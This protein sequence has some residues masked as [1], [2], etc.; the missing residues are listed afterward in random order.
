MTLAKQSVAGKTA[1]ITG[2]ASGIGAALVKQLCS[3]GA[4]VVA[5]DIQA[6]ALAEL[7]AAHGCVVHTADITTE[8]ANRDMVAT[9]VAAV[10]PLDLVFLNA[11]VLGRSREEQGQP[12]RVGELNPDHYRKVMAV[13]TDSVIY[14]TIA[15]AP[16]MNAGGGIIV[17]ASAAGLV[18]WEP[19]PFYTATKHAVVGWTRAVAGSLAEQEITMNA[20]CPGGVATALLGLSADVAK[21]VPSLLD[22]V[23]VAQA[24]IDTATSGATGTAVS[25]VANRDPIVQTH[26]FNSIPNFP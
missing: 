24:A 3:A 19:T 13:N 20:I 9:A 8:Q 1:L 26:D 17:T 4:R 11:G 5:V 25:V 6:D 22:P 7:E 2:A 12:Y 14:G 23:Q 21:D 10:G 18:P 15:A 16:H